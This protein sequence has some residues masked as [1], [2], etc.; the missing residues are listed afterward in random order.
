VVIIA[1][2]VADRLPADFPEDPHSRLRRLLVGKEPWLSPLE[3]ER[4]VLYVGMTRAERLV[5]LATTP[6]APTPFLE[7]FPHQPAPKELSKKATAEL[8]RHQR[9]QKPLEP[10]HAPYTHLY[11]YSF[12]PKRYLLEN[13]F[14]FAGR[15][16]P[17]LRAGISLHRA[18]E[19]LHRL[20]RDGERITAKRLPQ[21]FERSWVAPSK[22]KKAQKEYESIFGIFEGYAKS[23]LD[24]HRIKVVDVERP[25]Y[26]VERAGVLTGKVD[27]LRDCQGQRELVEFKFSENPL[28]R[29]YPVKQLEHYRLAFPD[30]ELQLVVH[31][32][33]NGKPKTIEARP[34]EE[35]R[36]EIAYT[37]ESIRARRFDATPG[38]G[39]CGI[40][41]VRFACADSVKSPKQTQA[42]LRVRQ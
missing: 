17:A 33:R 2:A 12:C 39:K 40:C 38:Q 23:F 22:S 24:D 25:F 41:P 1:E 9:P 28:A 8:T 3:E 19:I 27:L 35:V 42:N 21:I 37:L 20:A 34:P 4:R 36:A 26:V 29:D 30:E 32:L 10:M 18:L 5:V 7:E 16:I 11:N 6:D 13:R 14:G 31:Y 15:A